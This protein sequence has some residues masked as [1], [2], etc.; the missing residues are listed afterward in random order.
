ML[1]KV[2][3][4]STQALELGPVASSNQDIRVKDETDEEPRRRI[5]EV[6][7]TLEENLRCVHERAEEAIRSIRVNTAKEIARLLEDAAAE[8]SCTEKNMERKLKTELEKLS[9]SCISVR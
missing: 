5:A 4:S 2:S 6:D 9:S 3:S 1:F 8:K 7:V